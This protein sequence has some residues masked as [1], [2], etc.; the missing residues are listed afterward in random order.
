M[1][2]VS[3]RSDID[4]IIN[5]LNEAQ[6]KQVPFAIAKTLTGLAQKIKAAEVQEMEKVFD[7]PTRFT[8][9][10][11]FLKAATKVKPLA[12]VGLKEYAMKGTPATKYLAPQIAGGERRLKGF[13]VLLNRRGILPDGY[14]TV[15]AK[16]ARLDRHGNISKGLLNQILSYSRAQRDNAQNTKLSTGRRSTKARFIVLDEKGGKPGGIWAITS[17]SRIYPVLIFV[18]STRY[19][20]RFDF[21]RT[22][23]VIYKKNAVKDFERALTHAMTTATRKRG[24]S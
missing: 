19:A 14:Y 3:I 8:L 17:D 10:S 9:N 7:R 20:K 21:L 15:P 11:L 1:I 18:K 6:K 23:E 12:I 22:A 13:E 4:S 16:R 2:K 5:T 24:S